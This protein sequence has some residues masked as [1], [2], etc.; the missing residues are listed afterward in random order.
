MLT[1]REDNLDR[2][3]VLFGRLSV[4][5]SSVERNMQLHAN[6]ATHLVDIETY[7]T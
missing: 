1:E 4:K 5:T 3:C 6:A 2:E 7:S